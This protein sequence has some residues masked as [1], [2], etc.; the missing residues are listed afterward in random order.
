MA[1]YE[2]RFL[3][4]GVQ[5][6][7]RRQRSPPGL[8]SSRTWPAPGWSTRLRAPLPLFVALG[9]PLGIEPVVRRL[10]HWGR[11]GCGRP[12]VDVVDRDDFVAAEPHRGELC[13]TK[14]AVPSARRSASI[15]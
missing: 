14:K 1:V 7:A 12:L 5:A 13:L 9:S 3:P 4:E 8:R 15:A 10:T 11:P 6:A 2:A